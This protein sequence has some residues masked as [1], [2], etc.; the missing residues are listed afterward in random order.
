[1]TKEMALYCVSGGHAGLSAHTVA[2]NHKQMP[3][4][5]GDSAHAVLMREMI[6]NDCNVLFSAGL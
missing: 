2:V 3:H 5:M 1:M 4:L 6:F